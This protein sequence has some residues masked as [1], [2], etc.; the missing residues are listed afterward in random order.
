MVNKRECWIRVNRSIRFDIH[1]DSLCAD[2]ALSVDA[3]RIHRRLPELASMDVSGR[4]HDSGSGF[5]RCGEHH[6]TRET[7]LDRRD[8]NPPHAV[9]SYHMGTSASHTRRPDDGGWCIGCRRLGVCVAIRCRV[10]GSIAAP[11]LYTCL[12]PWN[13]V[14]EE[15]RQ[16]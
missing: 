10:V 6:A 4:D 16:Q 2:V 9:R 11:F 7:E 8:E 14:W 3:C 5:D 13:T 15:A 12:C 1:N